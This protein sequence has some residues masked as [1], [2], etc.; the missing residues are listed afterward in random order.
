MIRGAARLLTASNPIAVGVLASLTN[1][2][3][4][5]GFHYTTSARR[6]SAGELAATANTVIDEFLDENDWSGDLDRELFQRSRVDGEYFLG[7]WHVGKGHVQARAIEPDQVTE[8]SNKSGIEEWLGCSQTFVSN[9]G[10]GVHTDEADAQAVHGFYV[11]WS[12]RD[13][14][15]DYF[16]GGNEPIIPPGGSGTWV[17]HAKLNVVRSVKRGLSDF[18]PIDGNLELARRVL[19]NMG[20]GS[21]V[22]AAIAWIQEVA[23]GTTQAQVNTGTLSRADGSYTTLTQQGTSRTHLVQQY[24]PATILK[25]PSGQKY[26]PGPLGTQ[27]APNFITAAEALLRTVALRWS[28]PENLIT[29]SAANNNFASSLV[30]ETPFVKYAESQQQYY[31]QR[32]RKTLWRVLRFAWSAGRFG[33]VPWPT[34][35][36]ALEITVTPPQIEVRDPEKETRVRQMLHKAGV[37]SRKTWSAQESLDFDQEQKNFR[38][39]A[40]ETPGAH[41][42][43]HAAND[44]PHPTAESLEHWAPSKHPRGGNPKNIGEFSEAPGGKATA[45]RRPA[46]AKN[47]PQ[48]VDGQQRPSK[49]H[50]LPL[51]MGSVD[52]TGAPD[53]EAVLDALELAYRIQEIERQIEAKKKQINDNLH[54]WFFPVSPGYLRQLKAEQSQ[55]EQQLSDLQQEFTDNGYDKIRWSGASG[56]DLSNNI[57]GEGLQG[58]K[59]TLA[60]S[61]ALGGLQEPPFSDPLNTV[62]L[63]GG[64]VA[65]GIRVAGGRLLL[66]RLLKRRS[67]PKGGR[68]RIGAE[69]GRGAEG[70]VYES[71]D[72]SGWVVK[73]FRQGRTSPLQAR[74]EYSNL[75]KARAIHLENVVKAHAPSNPRQGFLVKEKVTPSSA[76]PDMAQRAQLLRDFQNIPDAGSNL[77]WGTTRGN[78]TPRWILIE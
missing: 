22:Q 67:V 61:G 6:R 60:G 11:Q 64:L 27:H 56:D 12:N 1:Y 37:L 4:G 30:A 29:G 52:V 45:A 76:P 77:I 13:T 71:P 48:D 33:D 23:P 46:T 55:L 5:N 54:S 51:M 50:R 63:V 35:R 10:F 39:E 17:E 38:Q 36:K 32:D 40:A 44:N 34:L 21:A 53:E 57:S 74:N 75:E 78:P 70:V 28:L 2:V 42:A 24:D 59:D 31:A 66:R 26:L 72:Q 41:E 7:L 49:P 8:P 9:W 16:P 65:G 19:R 20:E 15:W 25:V 68:P 62:P 3:I 69:L 58:A 14:D 73:V 43:R 18:F 47:G